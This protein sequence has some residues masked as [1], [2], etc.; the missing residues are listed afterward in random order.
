M[1]PPE[2]ALEHI[3]QTDAV[4]LRHVHRDLLVVHVAVELALLAV[5]Q[6]TAQA[7]VTHAL[8]HHLQEQ[9]LELARDLIERRILVLAR[10]RLQ[11]RQ[12]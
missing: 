2:L 11:G 3:G 7:G 5:H 9:R 10:T 6:A 8:E 4:L 12:P 1:P